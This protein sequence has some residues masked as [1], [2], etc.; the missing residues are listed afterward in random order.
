[1][2]IKFWKYQACGNDFIIIDSRWDNRVFTSDEKSQLAKTLCVCHF[3]IGANDVLFIENSSVADA[4]MIVFEPDGSEADMCGNG[5]RCVAAYLCKDMEKDVLMIET[6]AGIKKVQNE[7]GLF[8]VNMGRVINDAEFFKRYLN[9]DADN[10]LYNVKLDYN[11]IGCQIGSIVYTGEPNIVF[12]GETIDQIDLNLWGKNIS[13]DRSKFPLGI[14]TT[15]VEKVDS[16][17]I[18]A[19]FYEKGVY[20]ETMACGTGATAAGYVYKMLSGTEAKRIR[21]LVKGGEIYIEPGEDTYMIGEGKEVFSG[22]IE[23]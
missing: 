20:Q 9:F 4:Q 18:K 14:C 21:V 15:L 11:T 12:F 13:E 6:K 17:T 22:E 1:M 19:R 8:R 2:K 16:T 3:S 7:D 5:I 23:I 10:G